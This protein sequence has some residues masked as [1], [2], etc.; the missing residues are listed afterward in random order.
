MKC[1]FLIEEMKGSVLGKNNNP[2]LGRCTISF[3]PIR[4][5]RVISSA[6]IKRPVSN[7]TK[8]CFQQYKVL[9]LDYLSCTTEQVN[10]ILNVLADWQEL[11]GK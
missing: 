2:F 6:V 11:N 7:S 1:G 3:R 8:S 4:G 9:L 10:L 5:S